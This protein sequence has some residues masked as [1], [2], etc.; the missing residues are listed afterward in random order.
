MRTVL[1]PIASVTPGTPSDQSIRT[2]SPGV[3]ARM[4]VASSVV[5][6]AETTT[7]SPGW[8]RFEKHPAWSTL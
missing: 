8:S 2:L 5:G 1:P 7:P 4:N 3:S 6:T